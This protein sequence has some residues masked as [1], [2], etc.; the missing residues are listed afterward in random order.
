M[1]HLAG[2]PQGR[3]ECAGIRKPADHVVDCAYVPHLADRDAQEFGSRRLDV[4]DRSGV[5]PS[6]GVRVGLQRI[7][8][9]QIFLRHREF[10]PAA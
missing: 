6:E 8:R 1:G 7:R 5:A 9:R 10:T 4:A 2:D 3:L